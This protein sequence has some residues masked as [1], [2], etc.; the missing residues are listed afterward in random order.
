M[1]QVKVAMRGRGPVLQGASIAV[2]AFCL[3]L[4]LAALI[5]SPAATHRPFRYRLEP[6]GGRNAEEILRAR[7][8]QGPVNEVSAQA[9]HALEDPDDH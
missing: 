1:N 4:A 9:A 7:Y 6:S 3:G 2:V 8:P 5:R